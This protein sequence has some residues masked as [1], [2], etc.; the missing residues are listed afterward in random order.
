M[1]AHVALLRG[2][3]E[4]QQEG[5]LLEDGPVCRHRLRATAVTGAVADLGD[6]DEVCV[7]AHP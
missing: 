5:H 2:P 6:A 4:F 1:A 7:L 3:G